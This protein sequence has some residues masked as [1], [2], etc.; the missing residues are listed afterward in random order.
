MIKEA[1]N[2]LPDELMSPKY[3]AQALDMKFHWVSE[4]GAPRKLTC[5]LECNVT[6]STKLTLQ[7]VTSPI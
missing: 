1:M 3:K 2:E 5:G 6:V 4:D 7:S